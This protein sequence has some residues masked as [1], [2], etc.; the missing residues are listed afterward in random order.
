MERAEILARETKV[1]V[2]DQYGTIVD[3]QGDLTAAA[4]PFLK[5][6]GW[7]G[8][9]H[10]F[11]TWWRRTHYENSMIDALGGRGHTPYRQIGHRAVSY[12]MDRC[13]FD[14]TQAEVEWLVSQIEVLKP[15][16]DVLVALEKLRS[17]GYKLAILSNGDRD[18]L[19]AAKP[20]IGFPFDHVISVEESGYFKPHWKTYASAAEI[21]GADRSSCLFVANHAFDCIGA[22]CYGMR[23]AFI[24]R[25]KR[26]FGETPHQP[27]II[28]GNF[29]ELAVAL[30]GG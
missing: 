7:D 6:K 4:T 16:P 15:F 10:R 26:P 21:I 18:M 13:G 25:R 14:Y 12:V 22:K 24:D 3:M 20:H 8:E 30:T 19:D 5:A 1:L 9:A 29:S 23:T 17:A 28:V 11:V 2:F 27:D